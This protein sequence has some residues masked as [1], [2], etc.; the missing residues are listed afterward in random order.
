MF[1]NFSGA[2]PLCSLCSGSVTHP[3]HRFGRRGLA[4]SMWGSLRWA[5]LS[6][7][8]W[9]N[10]SDDFNAADLKPDLFVTPLSL[11]L[12]WVIAGEPFKPIRSLV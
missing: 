7:C 3:F 9:G 10:E 1:L 5:L 4:A 2:L 11:L 8:G 12:I 6:C